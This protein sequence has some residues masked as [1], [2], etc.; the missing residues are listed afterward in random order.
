MGG[1]VKTVPYD[2]SIMKRVRKPA[3]CGVCWPVG[4]P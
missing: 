1:T 3:H 4:V 2:T